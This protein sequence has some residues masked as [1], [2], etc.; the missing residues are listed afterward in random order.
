MG[1]NPNPS[2]RAMELRLALLVV[3]ASMP[4]VAGFQAAMRVGAMQPAMAARAP[5]TAM[6]VDPAMLDT[7]AI[8]EAPTQLLALKS[9]A[10]EIIDTAMSFV[11]PVG[12]AVGLLA[13]VKGLVDDQL[14]AGIVSQIIFLAVGGFFTFVFLALAVP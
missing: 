11:F 5:S 1:G 10:D 3:A 13:I 9:E 8:V 6:L 12:T 2:I 7:T 4:A 14:E